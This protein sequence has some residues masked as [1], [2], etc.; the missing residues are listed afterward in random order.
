MPAA[1]GA[2]V[3][4]AQANL[5]ELLAGMRDEYA[6]A[7]PE[8]LARIEI[9]WRE[10]VGGG[11]SPRAEL[12][13]TAHSM[14]GAAATF[15][16]PGVGEAARALELALQSVCEGAGAPSDRDRMR[17]EAGIAELVRVSPA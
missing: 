2:P 9:L 13:R 16:L 6:R 12:L 3:P 8:K 1:T 15:G 17:I 10:I 4:A 14:A 5:Q 11:D 7:L